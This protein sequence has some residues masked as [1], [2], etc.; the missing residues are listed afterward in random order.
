[1]SHPRVIS[2]AEIRAAAVAARTATEI[3]GILHVCPDTVRRAARRVGVKLP[4]GRGGNQGMPLIRLT[5]E[6]FAARML[7]LRS[8]MRKR[9][10]R[11]VVLKT[12]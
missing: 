7:M 5:S 3:C 10:S 6:E 1:M 11:R 4:D 12:A 9:R 2:D 8:T